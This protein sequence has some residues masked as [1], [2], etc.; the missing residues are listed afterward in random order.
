VTG[1]CEDR[2]AAKASECGAPADVAAQGCDYICAMASTDQVDCLEESNCADLE[3][4][5]EQGQSF[6]GIELPED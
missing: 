1:S 6:C 4:A 5:F 3:A 2:C